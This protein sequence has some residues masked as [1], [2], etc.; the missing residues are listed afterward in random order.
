MHH[1]L[2]NTYSEALTQSAPSLKVP[3][4]SIMEPIQAAIAGATLFTLH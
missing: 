3:F 4:G 1:F 2:L